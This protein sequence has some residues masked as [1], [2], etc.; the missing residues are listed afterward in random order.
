MQFAKA[1]IDLVWRGIVPPRSSYELGD[2][3]HSTARRT[4]ILR[5]TPDGHSRG[6]TT[7]AARLS[8]VRRSKVYLAHGTPFAS[9][10]VTPVRLAAT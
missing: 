4:R 5:S 7:R 1:L 3:K 2:R 9:T 6:T 10:F 8:T